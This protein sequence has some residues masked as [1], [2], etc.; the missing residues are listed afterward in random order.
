MTVQ[1]RRL[2]LSNES[3]APDTQAFREK[4]KPSEVAACIT[5][6]GL[7]GLLGLGSKVASKDD[8]G[9]PALDLL[10]NKGGVYFDK[11]LIPPDA[12]PSDKATCKAMSSE[13][14]ALVFET[15]ARVRRPEATNE[16]RY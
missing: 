10:T 3:L 6:D 4:L 16:G 2:P 15:T 12:I 8:E 5:F 9:N 14:G 1:P 13:A 7:R 11:A